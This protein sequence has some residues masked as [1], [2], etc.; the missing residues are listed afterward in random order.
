[1]K[2]KAMD[3]MKG[4]K[5]EEKFKEMMGEPLTPENEKKMRQMMRVAGMSAEDI[6]AV[7]EEMR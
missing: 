1:M 3:A 7:I 4:M 5:S 2:Q 6:D